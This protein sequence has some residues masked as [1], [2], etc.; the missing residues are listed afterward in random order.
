MATG[1]ITDIIDCP[2]CRLPA[3]KDEYYVVGEERVVC[4]W[5]G[6]NHLKTVNGTES[7]KGFGS[8]HY[9]PKNGSNKTVIRLNVPMTVTQRHKT[10]MDIQENYDFLHSGFYVWND[11]TLESLIGNKPQTIEEEYEERRKE[12]EYYREISF[13]SSIHDAETEQF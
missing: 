1:I 10:I 9:A 11:N 13:Y 4:N 3:Q 2:Q 12:A 5:C 8:I 7:N 6:Y